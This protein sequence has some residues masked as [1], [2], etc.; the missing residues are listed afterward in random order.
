MPREFWSWLRARNL[1]LTEGVL[2]QLS[3]DGMSNW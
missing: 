3:Y 2:C 1:T